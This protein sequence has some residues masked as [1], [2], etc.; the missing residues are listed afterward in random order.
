M[1]DRKV[2]SEH[3]EPI[4]Q[5][6]EFFQT[7]PKIK[8]YKV[9]AIYPL[10][11]LSVDICDANHLNAGLVA[12]VESRDLAI[13]DVYLDDME[14]AELR[15]TTR[16]DF[17]VTWLAKPRARPYM[18]TRSAQWYIT[19][20]QLDPR[21]NPANEFMHMQTIFQFEDTEMWIRATSP[22]L[23]LAAAHLEFFGYRS[24]IEEV[25]RKDL[26]SGL[27]PTVVPTEGWPGSET[28]AP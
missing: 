19:T 8:F 2:Y 9:K 21:T 3:F 1:V 7:F 14:L 16:E 27:K 28:P 18:T 12:T 22:V 20:V 13:P 23:N 11:Q 17:N 4:V 24:I 5:P 15:M 25:K 10:P 26:P 6:N